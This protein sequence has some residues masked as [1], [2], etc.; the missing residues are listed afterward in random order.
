MD[1]NYSIDE[2]LIAVGELNNRKKN[3]KSEEF[4]Q[5][6]LNIKRNKDDIP[7]GTLKLIEETERSL[8][9]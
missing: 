9:N 3:K 6:K 1:N 5:P 2:I 8:K 7:P 4:N